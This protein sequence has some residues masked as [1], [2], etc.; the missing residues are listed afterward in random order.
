MNRG[1][2][3]GA[4]SSMWPKWPGHSNDCNRHVAQLQYVSEMR[5]ECA[6]MFSHVLCTARA[7]RWVVEAA[8]VGPVEV[9]EQDRVDN[10][11]D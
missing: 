8:R 2:K 6:E 9:V 10:L 3:T 4:G 7:Q 5:V 1:W 11:S